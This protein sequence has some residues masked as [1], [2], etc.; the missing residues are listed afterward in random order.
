MLNQLKQEIAT[1]INSNLSTNPGNFLLNLFLKMSRY[2]L[3]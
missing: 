3:Q 2:N 1:E